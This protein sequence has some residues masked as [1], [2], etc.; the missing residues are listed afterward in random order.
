MYFI[1]QHLPL[2]PSTSSPEGI[3]HGSD[4]VSTTLYSTH[5][6]PPSRQQAAAA[7]NSSQATTKQQPQQQQ[8]PGTGTSPPLL[9]QQPALGGF[10]TTLH[11]VYFDNVAL[12]LYHGRLYLRPNTQTL[13][14]R[15]IG[16]G[17]GVDGRGDVL[18]P[19]WYP[20]KVVLER[21]IYREG[22]RGACTSCIWRITAQA[23]FYWVKDRGLH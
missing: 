4:G 9:L 5:Q 7:G 15:W 13:K 19:G 10:T 11:T 1:L 18:G 16:E 14:A 12:Q 8:R 20:D 3:E 6:R 2:L 22:W 21:K 23:V 17:T